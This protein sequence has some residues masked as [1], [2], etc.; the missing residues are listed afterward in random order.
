MNEGQDWAGNSI[1]MP[2]RFHVGCAVNPVA[3]D[4][5]LEL[6]RFHRKLEAGAD[7]VM[8]QPLYDMEQ[9]LAFLDRVG[10][11]P[12]PF[13]LGVMPLQSHRHAEFLHHELPGVTIPDQLRERM[14]LA[15]DRGIE[16]GIRQSQEFLAEAQAHVDGTYLMPSFG[17][18]EM[19]AELVKVLNRREAPVAASP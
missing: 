9:L 12:V 8:S 5:E 7:Y 11:I 10:K 1:G 15:G 18:Y 6:D 19:V 14:R 16:E 4:L 2:A 13:L 3:D 17:R